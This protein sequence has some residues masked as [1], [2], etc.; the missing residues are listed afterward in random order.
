[1][2][3][4]AWQR[5]S[6]FGKAE[7]Q[8]RFV[9]FVDFLG[10]GARIDTDFNAAIDLYDAILTAGVLEQGAYPAVDFQVMSDAF[11]A[12]SDDI[13][14]LIQLV[15]D[16]HF[17]A[18]FQN[19]LVRGGIARGRHVSATEAGNLYVVSEGLVRAVSIE[20]TVKNPCVALDK[21]IDVPTDYWLVDVNNF[22]KPLLYFQ[23]EV[24]VNPFNPMWGVSANNRVRMMRD[25][26]PD[27]APKYDWF[28]ELYSAVRS[29]ANLVPQYKSG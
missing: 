24:I 15:R 20:K 2:R 23:G 16:I 29:G 22:Q 1:M 9:A 26:Y 18:L 8:E 21:A 4:T 7:P 12:T 28:I 27:H 5:K 25:E 13:W 10:F 11:V 14:R 3:D 19:C 6:V 17:V